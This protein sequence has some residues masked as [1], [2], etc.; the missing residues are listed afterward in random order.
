MSRLFVRGCEKP[1]LERDRSQMVLHMPQGGD[2]GRTPH[3]REPL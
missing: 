3:G 1:R 2:P